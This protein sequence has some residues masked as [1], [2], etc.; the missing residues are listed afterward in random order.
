MYKRFLFGIPASEGKTPA[1]KL[2]QFQ[3]SYQ[4][5]CLPWEEV[6]TT[7]AAWKNWVN[8]NFGQDQITFQFHFDVDFETA[9]RNQWTNVFIIIFLFF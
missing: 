6:G 4:Q 9:Q 7:L 2:M 5:Q 3:N 8:G 1:M